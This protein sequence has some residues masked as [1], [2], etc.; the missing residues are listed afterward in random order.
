M[1]SEM[2]AKEM[3]GYKNAV[4]MY[5]PKVSNSIIEWMVILE[6]I[7]NSYEDRKEW[8]KSYMLKRGDEY[9]SDDE[10]GIECVFESEYDP[11]DYDLDG[12]LALRSIE[13]GLDVMRV[14]KDN[15]C[16]DEPM[17]GVEV[18]DYEKFVVSDDVRK[19]K[20]FCERY[21]LP[22]PTFYGGMCGEFE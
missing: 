11:D 3:G 8:V 14:Y 10:S 5:G 21:K 7:G 2:N 15:I 19:M 18:N 16:W 17:I 20:E 4:L 1:R 9:D 22:E 6:Y 13:M 12:V